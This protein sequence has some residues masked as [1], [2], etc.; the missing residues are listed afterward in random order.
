MKNHPL[1]IKI[2]RPFVDYIFVVETRNFTFYYYLCSRLR[3]MKSMIWNHSSPV[4]IS[5]TAI[6]FLTRAAVWLDIQFHSERDGCLYLWRSKYLSSLIEAIGIVLSTCNFVFFSA[7]YDSDILQITD[8]CCQELS[9]FPIT[10]L[11]DLW[12]QLHLSTYYWSTSKGL[13]H[14]LCHSVKSIMLYI[15]CCKVSGVVCH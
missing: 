8:K 5:R 11:C 13:K 2:T 9:F 4:L 3:S 12:I 6:L 15:L 7:K 10:T 14:N 1:L